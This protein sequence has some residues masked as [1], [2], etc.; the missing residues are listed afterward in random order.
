M[1]RRHIP[2]EKRT[3]KWQRRINYKRYVND[4]KTD[5]RRRDGYKGKTD[6]RRKD[7]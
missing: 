3:D 4:K 6:K 2:I 1:W 7:G 5:K